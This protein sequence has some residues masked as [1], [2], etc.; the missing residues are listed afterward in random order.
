MPAN[1]YVFLLG[2]AVGTGLLVMGLL[3]GYWLGAKSSPADTVERQQF[4]SFLQNLSSWTSDYSGDVDRYQKQLTAID[5]KFRSS[6]APPPEE[7]LQ[8]LQQIMQANKQLQSRLESAEQKLES[9]TDQ[10][11]SYLTEARTDGL[12][13]LFNRRA[14]DK[15]LD[16]LF[17]DWT[18]KSQDFSMGMIDI[19]HF[20]QIN[21][22]YGHPAGDAVLRQVSQALQRELGAEICVARYGGEE[23]AILSRLPNEKL[24]QLLDDVRDKI[25][26]LE[27]EHESQVINVS[28]SAG[29]A[30]IEAEDKIGK[31]VR[32]AD[33]ALYA[34][35]LGGRNRVYRHDGT[36]CHLVTKGNP[37]AAKPA[38][39]TPDATSAILDLGQS[40]SARAEQQQTNSRISERLQRIVKEE[41]RRLIE[42]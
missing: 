13:G 10:I 14:F 9:Q 6:A 35:K 18:K 24:A 8:T 28:L 29:A 16:G 27:V 26:R 41:S 42:R 4:L 23:F 3:L 2:L 40:E 15:A 7:M 33:E 12:T 17:S 21:D 38:T 37:T 31:L 30:Q 5:A 19:D 32:R 34:A 22:T 39:S 1:S 11:S 25:N 20:K 36:I